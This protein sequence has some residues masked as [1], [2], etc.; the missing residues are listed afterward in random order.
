[1]GLANVLEDFGSYHAAPDATINLSDVALE[2]QRLEAFEQGY[3]AGWDD[4]ITA[5]GD[6]QTRVSADFARNMQ[7]L[8]FTYH[9]A[10]NQLTKA[11]QPLLT[12][13]VT[14]VLPQMAQATLGAQVV[15]QL[16]EMA[17][18]EAGAPVE[19]VVSPAN[20]PS[21]TALAEQDLGL[22][23][24]IVEEASLGE[25]QVYLRFGEA[26]REINLDQVLG[27][28]SEAVDAF[29]HQTEQEMSHG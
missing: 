8:S 1:M 12:Q 18:T 27:G 4:A 10:F 3:K 17:R 25:G 23:I 11:L 24:T 26:E 28:I 29:F 2:E 9:D 14:K 15:E 20:A 19:V 6:D 21:I 7:D 22:P 13:V 5:Q 16:T